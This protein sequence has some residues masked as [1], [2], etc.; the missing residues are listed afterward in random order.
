MRPTLETPPEELFAALSTR[1]RLRLVALL[2]E[3]EVCVCHLVDALDVPQPTVSRH[4]AILRSAGLV[5]CRKEGLWCHYSLAPAG[6]SLH[7][8]LLAALAS[9]SEHLPEA[10]ADRRRLK[11]V[12]RRACC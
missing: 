8:N 12:L 6:G 11:A 1:I 2:S 5:R 7:A 10:A 4:L 3:G 9:A